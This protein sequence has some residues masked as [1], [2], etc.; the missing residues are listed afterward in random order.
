MT[1][2]RA[3]LRCGLQ[4]VRHDLY[5]GITRLTNVTPLTAIASTSGTR[6]ITNRRELDRSAAARLLECVVQVEG[7]RAIPSGGGG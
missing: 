7:A 2:A 6:L 3:I 1:G 4:I 5:H